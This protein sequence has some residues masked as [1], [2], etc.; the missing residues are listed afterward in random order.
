ME[1]AFGEHRLDIKR[2]ELRRAD[3]LVGLEPQVFDLLAYLVEHRER[4]VGK[5]ICCALSGA[6]GSSRILPWPPASM[7]RGGQSAM[8]A[9]ASV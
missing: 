4:V 6:D 1:Y 9:R 2:R 5:T 3:A 8:M 7:R